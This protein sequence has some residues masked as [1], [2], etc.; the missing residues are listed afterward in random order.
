MPQRSDHVHVVPKTDSLP[1]AMMHRI[2]GND[3]SRK[4]VMLRRIRGP[5][6][7]IDYRFGALT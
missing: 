7:A 4:M 2:S 1:N 3:G 5:H 6:G